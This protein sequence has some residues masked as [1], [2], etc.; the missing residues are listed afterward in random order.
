MEETERQMSAE[1][2]RTLAL[3]AGLPPPPSDVTYAEAVSGLVEPKFYMGRLPPEVTQM[4]APPVLYRPR[5]PR[6]EPQPES[7]ARPTP[8][9]LESEPLVLFDAELEAMFPAL[10]LDSVI[11]AERGEQAW[12]DFHEEAPE[13]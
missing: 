1:L 13:A 3:P 9:P 6:Q 11:E 12:E 8:P 10:A 4:P 5:Q 7:F 2:S